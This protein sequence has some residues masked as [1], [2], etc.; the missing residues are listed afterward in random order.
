VVR[1]EWVGE[2]PH[3]SRAWKGDGIGVHPEVKL[4]REIIVE[5]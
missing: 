2:H 1:L 4:G 3:R 5:M